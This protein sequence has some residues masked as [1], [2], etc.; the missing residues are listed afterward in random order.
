MRHAND[1]ALGNVLAVDGYPT[2]QDFARKETADGGG[3]AHC[4]VDASAEVGAALQA[5]ALVDIFNG[6]EAGADF[7][8]DAGEGGRVADEVE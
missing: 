7:G 4:F 1:G 3:Q 6:S 5:R 2:G 8:G